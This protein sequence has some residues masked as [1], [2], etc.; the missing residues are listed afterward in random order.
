M[1][2][3]RPHIGNLPEKR[4]R[5]YELMEERH[6]NA[7]T[8]FRLEQFLSKEEPLNGEYP[9]SRT[10]EN[11]E[12][13]E[14]SREM[15]TPILDRLLKAGLITKK[16]TIEL[17]V[18]AYIEAKVMAQRAEQDLEE[19]AEHSGEKPSPQEMGS[20]LF[21]MRMGKSPK[22]KVEAVRQ[23]GYFMIACFDD[24][25]YKEL[26]GDSDKEESGG[27]FHQKMSFGGLNVDTLLIRGY[28]TNSIF[29]HERQHFI[30]GVIFGGFAG[31]SQQLINK[32]NFPLLSE[33]SRR[34]SSHEPVLSNQELKTKY[35]DI[36]VIQGL[37]NVKDEVL[38]RIRD[39][40]NPKRA[41]DFFGLG[42]YK[43]L[44][45]S[46]SSDEKQEV[47]TLLRNIESELKNAHD[48][49]GYP[50]DA[51]RAILVYH[52]I[53]VPL[54]KF[55]ER[56]KAVVSFINEKIREF[57]DFIPNEIVENVISNKEKREHLRKLRL[58]ITG[59]AYGVISLTLGLKAIK[60]TGP[61]KELKIVKEK[62]A[63]LRKEY[64]RLLFL[65]R[66]S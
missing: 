56:I 9:T 36:D 46:F 28:R 24:E 64:D 18:D 59:E 21:T 41:T 14:V 29:L 4:D 13:I 1:E 10:P 6:R 31:F 17:A 51:R 45:D 53:D 66:N 58:G 12:K 57:M 30:N 16:E 55:P 44:R 33:T 26:S 49:F 50:S 25:D 39:G 52:L 60:S 61:E 42:L 35:K 2:K 8:A 7:I 48:I 5:R 22:G 15:L 62:I 37:N 38:A 40:S 54:L 19:L 43:Y 23:E 32:N 3:L 47:D 65:Y 20:K 34:Y 27:R 63:L 11:R